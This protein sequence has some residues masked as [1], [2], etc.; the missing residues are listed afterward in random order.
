[1]WISPGGTSRTTTEPAPTD[2]PSP[3]VISGRTMEPAPTST[4]R[5]IRTGR[6]AGGLVNSA[7]TVG[8]ERY[9]PVKSSERENIFEPGDRPTKSQISTPE[10]AVTNTWVAM[11]TK[12]P[13]VIQPPAALSIT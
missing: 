13:M 12:S 10:P 3:M 9:F 7:G 4:W 11:W 6:S 2:E 5:P 1:M 8:L